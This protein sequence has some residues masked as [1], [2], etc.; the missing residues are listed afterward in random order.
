M[1]YSQ[2][3]NAL[4]KSIFKKLLNKAT[5]DQLPL[6]AFDLNL[7]GNLFQS[8]DLANVEA[9]KKLVSN[10]ADNFF[11]SKKSSCVRKQRL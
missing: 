6:K 1:F 8:K 7:S 4:F 2:T 5:N 11:P 3:T 9:N 10:M